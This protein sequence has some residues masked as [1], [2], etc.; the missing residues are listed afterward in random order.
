MRP[1]KT[2]SAVL[3]FVIAACGP[4]SAPPSPPATS[5]TSAASATVAGPSPSGLAA[6]P[7]AI[8][9]PLRRWYLLPDPAFRE[10]PRVVVTFPDGDPAPGRPRARLRSNGRVVDLVRSTAIPASWSAVLPLDDAPAGPQLVEILVRLRGGE[11]AVVGTREFMLSAPEY[12]VWTLDFEGDAAGDEAMNNT[13]AIGGIYSVPLTIMWNPRVWTT[14]QVS[15]ERADAMRQW[16]M[17]VANAGQGEVALHLHAWTDFVRAAGVTPRVS[18]SWAA[19]GDGYDVPLTAFDEAETK[20][21][22]DHALK[23]MA[24]NGMPRPTSFRGGGLFANAA[25]LRAAAAAGFSVDTSATPAGDFGLL[26]LPWTL[27]RDAQPYRPSATDANVPGDLPLLEVPNIAGN[28]YGLTSFS[29]QRV[30][31]D[32]L[33]MLAPVGSV[34]TQ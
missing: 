17:N 18:P 34:A 26:R 8:V 32:D 22:I 33:A 2:T 25:N 27:P 29:I 21:L 15:R 6:A 1:W 30:V 5:G 3:A 20:K 28:T 24:D 14:T 12:V 9:G 10:D 16:T 13:Y 23:L 11:D 19:R 7:H 31:N 4:S